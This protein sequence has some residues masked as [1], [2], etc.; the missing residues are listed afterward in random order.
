MGQLIKLFLFCFVAGFYFGCGTSSNAYLKSKNPNITWMD[1][2]AVKKKSEFPTEF[3]Y[4][5]D[6]Y[7][8]LYGFGGARPTAIGFGGGLVSATVVTNPKKFPIFYQVNKSNMTIVKSSK[9]ADKEK[10]DAIDKIAW[11]SKAGWVLYTDNPKSKKKSY[12]AK[13]ISLDKAEKSVHL[14]DLE[15]DRKSN[16]VQDGYGFNSDSTTLTYYAEIYDG[17]TDKLSFITQCFDFVTMEKLWQHEYNYPHTVKK[18]DD[19]DDLSF[20]INKNGEPQFIIKNYFGGKKKEKKKGKDGTMEANYNFKFFVLNKAGKVEEYTIETKGSFINSIDFPINKTANPVVC[21]YTYKKNNFR[22]LKSLIFKQINLDTKEVTDLKE[23]SFNTK[24]L[25][26][27]DEN[28]G[29][30]V[31]QAG[32]TDNASDLKIQDIIISEDNS[33]YV[34]GERNYIYQVCHTSRGRTYCYWKVESGNILI[35]KVNADG[36]ESWSKIIPK[37]QDVRYGSDINS[38]RAFEIDNKIHIFFNDHV[39]NYK[40]NKSNK[41]YDWTGRKTVLT[42][43]IVSPDGTYE[44][45]ECL[46]EKDH[47]VAASIPSIQK[48]DDNNIILFDTKTIGKL[49]IER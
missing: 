5:D 8:Y 24:S 12:Y 44:M 48:I 10:L 29:K 43:V 17:K 34:L 35:T 37:S 41:V 18:R 39:K 9:E 40:K 21:A 11:T 4:Q 38:F 47:P 26:I 36:T 27:Y 20:F 30:K 49:T 6:D 22:E 16:F 42:H 32:T 2:K 19:I 45:I 13:Q 14:F 25:A 1:K 28:T 7:L 46:G 31:K 3:G 23:I 33:T 15:T